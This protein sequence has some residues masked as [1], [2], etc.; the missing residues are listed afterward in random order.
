V[1]IWNFFSKATQSQKNTG[2][3]VT[4]R[5]HAGASTLTLVHDGFANTAQ[6]DDH[7]EGWDKTMDRLRAAGVSRG[8]K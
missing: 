5:E 4:I 6:C 3:T 1:F 7:N 8:S 2:V